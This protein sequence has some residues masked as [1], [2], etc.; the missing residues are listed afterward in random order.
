MIQ[1]TNFTVLSFAGRP[2]I[3]LT[4]PHIHCFFDS[5]VQNRLWFVLKRESFGLRGGFHV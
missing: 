1:K 2:S 4:Q 5:A 3:Q